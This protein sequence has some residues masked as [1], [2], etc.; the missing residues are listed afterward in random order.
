[1]NDIEAYVHAPLYWRGIHYPQ[2]KAF[3]PAELAIAI[4]VSATDV[5]A[6]DEKSADPAATP[7]RKT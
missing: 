1:M 6:S 4:G 5:A 2:G 3:I 7:K